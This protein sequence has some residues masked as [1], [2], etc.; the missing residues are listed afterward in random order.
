ML[1]IKYSNKTTGSYHRVD[2]A[3]DLTDMEKSPKKSSEAT[4][5]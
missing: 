1:S 2:L 3:I 5:E 4:G